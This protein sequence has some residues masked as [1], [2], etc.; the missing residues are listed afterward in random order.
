M[1]AGRKQYFPT[2]FA[3]NSLNSIKIESEYIE[4]FPISSDARLDEGRINRWRVEWVLRESVFLL[5]E[6]I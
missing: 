1:E 2:V 6:N 4:N 5:F 3:G